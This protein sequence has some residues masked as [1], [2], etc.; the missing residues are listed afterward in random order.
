MMSRSIDGQSS[1]PYYGIAGSI[2]GSVTGSVGPAASMRFGSAT[3]SMITGSISE[4]TP[5]NSK[6][7]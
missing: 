6:L 4:G 5:L 2:S 3:D 7:L 1:T